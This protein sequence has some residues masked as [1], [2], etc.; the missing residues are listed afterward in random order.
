MYSKCPWCSISTSSNYLGVY[1]REKPFYK[2]FQCIQAKCRKYYT[3]EIRTGSQEVEK[4]LVRKEDIDYYLKGRVICPLCAVHKKKKTVKRV[5]TKSVKKS[6]K[7]NVKKVVTKSVK[8][9]VRKS[10]KKK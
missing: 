6:V 5:V 9:P 2:I 7:K 4:K 3:I 1:C 8:K 10:V